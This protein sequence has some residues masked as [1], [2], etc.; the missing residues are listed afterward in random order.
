VAEPFVV[1]KKPSSNAP[2]RDNSLEVFTQRMKEAH[3][4]E[5]NK[6]RIKD[7]IRRDLLFYPTFRNALQGNSERTQT[8]LRYAELYERYKDLYAPVL[9]DDPEDDWG[10][11]IGDDPLLADGYDPKRGRSLLYF[12]FLFLPFG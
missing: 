4:E 10:N 8:S 5:N 12:I 7:I 6:T 2:S 3:E 11:D 1:G 9:Y